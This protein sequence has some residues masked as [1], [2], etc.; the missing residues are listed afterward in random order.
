MEDMRSQ[1]KRM[2]LGG[3]FWAKVAIAFSLIVIGVSVWVIVKGLNKEKPIDTASLREELNAE[4]EGVDETNVKRL[5]EI[6]DKYLEYFEGEELAE[7]YTERA[8]KIYG[9]DGEKKYGRR[10]INDLIQAD[11]ILGTV[12]SAVEICNCANY[13]GDEEVYK[14]YEAILRE[15]NGNSDMETMG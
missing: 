6:Y 8:L 3:S 10:V 13:Y 12:N 4:L 1:K 14:K 2:R 11:D 9:I 5:V 7:I 15:R